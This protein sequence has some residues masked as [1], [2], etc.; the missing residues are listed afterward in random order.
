MYSYLLGERKI[1][2]MQPTA[3]GVCEGR[4]L[5]QV[6]CPRSQVSLGELC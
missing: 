1:T 6:F 2:K 3:L 4:I 5:R